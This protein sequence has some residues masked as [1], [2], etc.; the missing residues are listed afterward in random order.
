M[1]KHCEVC[2]KP[3]ADDL[4]ACPH[5]AE[6]LEVTVAEEHEPSEASMVVVELDDAAK[7]KKASS[8]SD[9]AIDL[10]KP[11]ARPK[12]PQGSESD[13]DIGLPPARKGVPTPIRGSESDIDIGLPPT[14]APAGADSGVVFGL[15]QPPSGTSTVEWVTLVEDVTPPLEPGVEIDSPS[16]KDL[17]K[18]AVATPDSSSNVGTGKGA[19]VVPAD[20]SSAVNLGTLARDHA[21]APS[22]LNLIHEAMESS[23]SGVKLDEVSDETGASGEA[24]VELAEEPGPSS[25]HLGD[26]PSDVGPGSSSGL[27]LAILSEHAGDSSHVLAEE[28]EADADAG[29]PSGESLLAEL[30]EHEAGST[31]KSSRPPGSEKTAALLPGATTLR[32]PAKETILSTEEPDFGAAEDEGEESSAVDLGAPPVVTDSDAAESEEEETREADEEA[33]EADETEAEQAEEEEEAP[34]PK[35]LAAAP[36]GSKSWPKILVGSVVGLIVGASAMFGAH[37]FLGLG[38]D[39]KPDQRQQVQGDKMPTM[40]DA[41]GFL[42]GGDPDKAL[43]IL[44]SQ[45]DTP[46]IQAARGEA[47]WLKYR[48]EK[49]MIDANDPLFKDAIKD[50]EAA[51]AANN[52]DALF[53]QA[54]IAEQTPGK[55]PAEAR[56]LYQ[57]AL[58]R[59]KDDPVQSR[60]FQAA[61]DR[62]DVQAALTRPGVDHAA[63]PERIEA[64]VLLMTALQH[65]ADAAGQDDE[66]GFE[67][68]KAVKLAQTAKPQDYKEALDKLKKARDLH[69]KMRFK[70]LRKAQNPLS[71]PT[72]AIFLKCCDEL[73]AYWTLRSHLSTEGYITAGKPDPVKA[74]DDLIAASTILRTVAA[75]LENKDV[76]KGIDKL[77]DDKKTADKKS[78]DLDE[79]LKIAK[80]ATDDAKK[81]TDAAKKEAKDIEDKLKASDGLLKAADAKLKNAGARIAAAGIKEADVAKG[82]DQLAA[83]RVNADAALDNVVKA[84]KAAKYLAPD[85]S[86]GD[87]LKGVDKAVAMAKTVDPA[88]KLAAAELEIKRQ[89]DLL[90]QRKSPQQM[91]DMWLKVLRENPDPQSVEAALVDAKRSEADKQSTPEDRAKAS[92]VTGMAYRTQLKFPEARAALQQALKGAPEKAAWKATPEAVLRELTD[93]AA[94]Y[95][96]L[97]QQAHDLRAYFLAIRFLDEG[98]KA[99]PEDKGRLLAARSLAHLAEAKAKARGKL[100]ADMPDV[101]AGS[102]DAQDAISS[103]AKAEGNYAAGQLAEALG[104]LAAARKIYE[105][106]LAAHSA[107]DL[108]GKRYRVAL[109]RVLLMM[110]QD[111]DAP[112]DKAR[113][114]GKLS[115]PSRALSL[116][117]PTGEPDPLAAVILL[118]ALADDD[119]QGG[120]Q[121]AEERKARE[122]ADEV[123]KAKPVSG[124]FMVRSQAYAVQG[125]WNQALRTYVDGLLPLIPQDYAD[126]LA[127]LLNNHP[128]FKRPDSLAVPNVL[129]A[130]RAYANGLGEFSARRY[131]QAEEQFLAAVKNDDQDARYFYYLGLSRWAQNKRDKRAEA[132]LDFERGAR[133]EKQNRPGTIVVNEALERVQGKARQEMAKYRK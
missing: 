90:A 123:L 100:K 46:E 83:A 21:E 14:K 86:R 85:A 55:G 75:K 133:L 38:G 48:R 87:A 112:P 119:D 12:V 29:E 40:D 67:F 130:E 7:S 94:H 99:F 43:P 2:K 103:G 95:L 37:S 117:M 27:D 82:V 113:G 64:L 114:V 36:A 62:L 93:P 81:A 24:V 47:R 76:V 34:A 5:C 3:Y 109:A 72:E 60:R 91:L 31:I 35:R 120:Q 63:I 122:L 66:A 106:A 77:L 13:L 28:E 128:A 96:P 32:K 17:L 92:A 97:A 50:L 129:E 102:K 23:T 41:K 125:L 65:P 10:G 132:R 108:D 73:Q 30:D 59:F 71:D 33:V 44:E 84:L 110:R 22:D 88:G 18:Q 9:S 69:D 126:G 51:A 49:P 111:N 11:K 104:D 26:K 16:D 89:Q 78:A 1:A 53:W 39:K 15:E 52:A 127:E 19:S 118:L 6:A 20:E 79:Q 57:E 74:V 45:G 58:N 115:K 42:S 61:I 101:V 131:V 56:K 8:G 70:R 98:L 121:S 116:F 80:K 107:D 54:Q 105:Q 68:W 124:D 4:D 25:V